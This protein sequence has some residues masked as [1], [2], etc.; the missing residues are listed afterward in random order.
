MTT[1]TGLLA[2]PTKKFIRPAA[3]APVHLKVITGPAPCI[4]K[5]F[6]GLY[7][8]YSN[9]CSLLCNHPA[10]F[11][12]RKM[13]QKAKENL[14]NEGKLVLHPE[15]VAAIKAEYELN[16]QSQDIDSVPEELFR[17]YTETDSRPLTPA[18][19]M[20][21]V[22]T[23]ASATRRCVTPE[24]FRTSEV[25]EK[26]MLV[27]DLRRSH[28]QET[29]SWYGS[30]QPVDH[31]P[32]MKIMQFG[33]AK[34]PSPSSARNRKQPPA[35]KEKPEATKSHL[36]PPKVTRSEDDDDDD[37]DDKEEEEHTL[38]RRGKRRKRRGRNASRVPSIF[39]VPLDP[40]TLVATIGPDSLN[41]S[42]R[43]S[44]V[45]TNPETNA[46]IT[47]IAASLKFGPLDVDSYL[48]YDVLKQLRR[49]LTLEIVE[50]EFN[51]ERRLALEEALKTVP[52]IRVDCDELLA[53][54]ANLKMPKID[55][56]FW[57]T[58]PRMFTRSSVR[59]ELPMDSRTMTAMTPIKYVQHNVVITSTRKMLYNFVFNI[60]KTEVVEEEDEE[61]ECET[62]TMRKIS[63]SQLVD[64][65]GAVMGQ[66][67]GEEHGVFFKDL[68]GWDVEECYDFRTFSGICGLA[69]RILARKLYSELPDRK[70]DPCHEIE[71]VDFESLEFKLSG[72]E[73]DERL[74]R[75]LQMI[76]TL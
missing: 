27:L 64:A 54:Q 35:P 44:L 73:V 66:K 24:P 37:D 75:I 50:N 28:S 61:K 6:T 14:G 16:F 56:Q 26:T 52:K 21:S 74:V 23:R 9:G 3:R 63:G 32:L 22:H 20:I 72:K 67:L 33:T 60:F 12:A 25:R 19:T 7:N 43:H 57:L 34:L 38:K 48:D 71:R 46:D 47:K 2:S 36:E 59:F 13:I 10:D 53:L 45:A 62:Q 39:Q 49:E 11:H 42:A 29:L 4:L 17:K 51:L 76:K 18:P 5:P 8:P 41:T 55:A 15:E 30:S 58:L 65:L 31:P 69:E 68:V 1:R 70:S 40:E